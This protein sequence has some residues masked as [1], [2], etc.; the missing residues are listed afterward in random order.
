[1][2][3]ATPVSCNRGVRGCRGGR[4][5]RASRLF[6]GQDADDAAARAVIFKSDAAGDLRE[7]GVVFAQSRIE[8]RAEPATA[9]PDDDR[10]TCHQ[11]TVVSLDA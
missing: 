5:G 11:I 3:A 9:L 10:A 8:T 7:D 2:I 4:R 1:M 6:D